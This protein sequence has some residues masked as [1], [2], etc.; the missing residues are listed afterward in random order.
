MSDN[1]LMETANKFYED[2]AEV[3]PVKPT[4]EAAVTEEEVQDPP[5]DAET[6]EA[7]EESKDE[8]EELEGNDD[9][10]ES[11][12]VEIDGKE[13]DL[14]DVRKW[15]DGHMMQS[16]YT[17][18][19]TNLA[20]E[21]KTFETER[22]TTRENLLKSQ[23]EISEMSDLLTVLVQEDEAIDWVELKE[24]DPDRYIELKELA[25]KRKEALAKVKAE[26]E[27]PANDPA[28]IAEEQKK[29]FS[30]NPD[31][32][33]DKG[34]P[35]EA[36]NN[37][38]SLVTEYAT[39]AG[40]SQEEFGQMSYSHHMITLLKAAKYDQLQEKGREIK[41]KREKIPVVTKPKAPKPEA[42]SKSAADIFYGD[43]TG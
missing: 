5:Q 34:Q 18:K 35:T 40:F 20:E 13:I 21:R 32:F 6:L 2:T 26:R 8:T 10:E 43:K 38:T 11:H 25:D 16:D 17:K 28:V 23:A 1:P 19:T 33:D 24:D 22:D 31:W 3:E 37:D 36:Y 9:D 4:K 7:P 29:L 27:V 14:E 12:Y 15:R 30:A 41:S 39:R 42:Q